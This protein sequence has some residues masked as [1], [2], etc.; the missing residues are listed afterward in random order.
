M[1]VLSVP[2]YSQG[3]PYQSALASA[4]ASHNVNVHIDVDFTSRMRLFSFLRAASRLRKRDIV[5]IH[6]S[7]F[8]LL[9]AKPWGSIV[10]SCLFIL[11]LVLLKLGG[12]KVVWTVH[13]VVNHERRH[14]QIELFFKKLL[15]SLCNRMIVHCESAKHAVIRTYGLRNSKV[16]VVPHGHYIGFYKNKIG[17]NDARNLL[18]IGTKDLVFLNFGAIRPYKGIPELIEAFKKQTSP[19]ATLLIAG[20][21]LPVDF[22]RQIEEEC[23]EDSRIRAVLEFIAND[24]VQVYMS[25][26]DVVVMPFREILTSGGVLLA[27]SFAKAIIAPRLGCIPEILNEQGA[28]LYDRNDQ[29]GLHSAL[30]KACGADLQSMGRYNFQRARQFDWNQIGKMTYEVYRNTSGQ[31]G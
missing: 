8:F 13:N 23:K 31:Y 15:T 18:K 24:Q 30:E 7:T 22:G 20:M 16:A 5:H 19:G 27:M 6:W 29:D 10:K 9:S 14:W 3:N 26:S 11:G 21:P 1:N 2:D 4:L 25:A 17:R 12:V 28:I